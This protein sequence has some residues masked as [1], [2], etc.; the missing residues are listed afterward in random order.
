MDNQYIANAI[1]DGIE[2]CRAAFFSKDFHDSLEA[3]IG[4]LHSSGLWSDDDLRAITYVVV[5]ET[6]APNPRGSIEPS[7]N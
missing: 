3:Y 6:N 1:S 2:H 4:Q 5:S 7:L